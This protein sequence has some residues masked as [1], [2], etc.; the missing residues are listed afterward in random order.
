MTLVIQSSR[1]FDYYTGPGQLSFQDLCD[2]VK[3]CKE[4]KKTIGE[5]AISWLMPLQAKG[6]QREG[7]L[8]RPPKGHILDKGER[9][10]W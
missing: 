4:V 10:Y 9:K 1:T 5:A 6:P 7:A 8:Q 3:E 2:L